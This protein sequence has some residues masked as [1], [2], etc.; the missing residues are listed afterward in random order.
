MKRWFIRYCLTK[1]TMAALVAVVTLLAPAPA[2]A[3]TGWVHGGNWAAQAGLVDNVIAYPD[4]ITASST[5]AQAQA[6]ADT[7]A[8]DYESV[9]I[10]FV[11]YPV[12]P[13]TVT[14]NWP[15]TQ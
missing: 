15:V 8:L 13:A 10:N 14:S 6:A 4:G 9:G 11:R 12:N 7:V 3:S 2:Q 5:V 1:T